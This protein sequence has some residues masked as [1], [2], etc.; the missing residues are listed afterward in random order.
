[1]ET[2]QMIRMTDKRINDTLNEI[3]NTLES[4]GILMSFLD[5]ATLPDETNDFFDKKE[6]GAHAPQS[7]KE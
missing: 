2:N 7:F 6:K 1:M 5:L 3:Q 4:N